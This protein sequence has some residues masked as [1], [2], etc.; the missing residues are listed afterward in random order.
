MEGASFE[1]SVRSPLRQWAQHTSPSQYQPAHA[2]GPR[3]PRPPA[4]SSQHQQSQQKAAALSPLLMIHHSPR[5]GYA[6][7]GLASPLAQSSSGLG[8]PKTP[9]TPL[10][11][12]INSVAA[13]DARGISRDF[14]HSG[15]M[16]G[17]DD[18]WRRLGARILPLFNGDRVVGSVEENSEMVRSCLLRDADGAWPEIHS[19]LRV[20][21]ASLVRALYRAL[22]VPP[23]FEAPQAGQPPVL[24]VAGIV[25]ADV[26]LDHLV[27]AVAGVWQTLY[28]HV[29][30]YLDG[31][32]LPLRLFKAAAARRKA[33]AFGVRHAVLL[34]FRDTIIMPLLPSLD[35]AAPVCVAAKRRALEF[36]YALPEL[37]PMAQA[38]HMLSVLAALTPAD[39][40]PLHH[41]ARS[42][43][44][45]L[46][47]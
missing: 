43:A 35:A 5:I 12:A 10:H 28:S 39:R 4:Q 16:A 42:M 23:K 3:S 22:G 2:G 17:G 11:P 45:A 33:D 7:R 20:G 44:T 15:Q 31:V 37:C 21:M 8:T 47:S 30:P 40:G 6:Q 9:T 27:A 26:G 38:V 25:S 46:H 34:H 29:L 18:R 13:L 32:F 19:I 24:S 1:A 14:A 41:S 36:G